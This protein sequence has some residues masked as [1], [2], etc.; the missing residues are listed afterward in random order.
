MSSLIVSSI[1]LTNLS[2]QKRNND[3]IFS[4]NNPNNK[5]NSINSN[6]ITSVN[7]QKNFPSLQTFIASFLNSK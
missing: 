4:S 1:A 2:H 5:S 6:K 7:K 3:S